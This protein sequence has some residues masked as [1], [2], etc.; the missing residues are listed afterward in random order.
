MVYAIKIALM[1]AA[2]VICLPAAH[3]QWCDDDFSN[4]NKCL[5]TLLSGEVTRV[6][7]RHGQ[8]AFICGWFILYLYM[9]TASESNV[10]RTFSAISAVRNISGNHKTNTD[11]SCGKPNGFRT[12]LWTYRQG[13]RIVWT[14]KCVNSVDWFEMIYKIQVK[15]KIK[16]AAS[17]YHLSG[18]WR[19]IR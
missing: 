9:R 11:S 18:D 6:A 7:A 19:F 3:L 12:A 14:D 16:T 10:V 17:D 4:A 2:M 13:A 8:S 5:R 15:Q 1:T